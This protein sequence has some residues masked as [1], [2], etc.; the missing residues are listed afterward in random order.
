MP[1]LALVSLALTRPNRIQASEDALNKLIYVH[2]EAVSG[3]TEAVAS[4]ASGDVEGKA[5]QREHGAVLRSEA[6]VASDARRV[7]DAQV[8]A[9][10]L[11]FVRQEAC[12]VVAMQRTEADEVEA[13]ALSREARSA[14]PVA[15]QWQH[16]DQPVPRC[17][18]N[19]VR[20]EWHLR[21]NMLV[22]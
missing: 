8:S 18:T 16:D 11:E 7:I 19:Y 22:A 10:L 21:C 20:W 9:Q 15:K 1:S 14:V 13:S 2:A 5:V 12:E 6:P 3:P 4:V 17:C